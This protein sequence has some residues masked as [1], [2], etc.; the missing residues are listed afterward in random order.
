[1]EE[2]TR[3]LRVASLFDTYAGV[4]GEPVEEMGERCWELVASGKPAILAEPLLDAIVIEDSQSDGR[5]AD[6]TSTDENGGW[7]ET[8]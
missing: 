2:T 4:L 3:V 5:F 8:F 7:S 6:P 1:V